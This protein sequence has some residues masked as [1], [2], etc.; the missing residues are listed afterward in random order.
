MATLYGKG[1]GKS[2][3]HAPR[4]EKPYWSNLKAKEV[5]ELVVELANKEIKPVK[6]GL[7]LRDSYGVYSVKAIT[8]KKIK[9]ILEE[10]GIEV[11]PYDIIR[12]ERRIKVLKKHLEKNKKDTR[13]KRGLQ[14]TEAKLRRLKKYYKKKRKEK[15]KKS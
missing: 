15:K 9:K 14:L 4:G 8:G 6:M 3:S 1:R 5:E 7:I 12:I 10:K 11:E 13:A 2:G